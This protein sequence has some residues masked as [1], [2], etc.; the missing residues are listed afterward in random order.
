VPIQARTEDCSFGSFLAKKATE[1]DWKRKEPAPLLLDTTRFLV[2]D[3]LKNQYISG[4]VTTS[5]KA[6]KQPD[7]AKGRKR[8]ENR[9]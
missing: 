7:S 6:G 3:A 4:P 9:I 1:V 2:L 5:G 8:R